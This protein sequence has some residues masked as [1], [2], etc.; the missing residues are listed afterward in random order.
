MRGFWSLVI[1]V[2]LL[3]CSDTNI[4]A[5]SSP[6]NHSTSSTPYR[7]PS[8]VRDTTWNEVTNWGF[9]NTLNAQGWVPFDMSKPWS[10]LYVTDTTE[11]VRKGWRA[12][13]FEV[14]YG[15]CYQNDCTRS[16]VYERNEWAENNLGRECD[17]KECWYGYSFYAPPPSGTEVPWVFFGQFNQHPSGRSPWMFLKRSNQDFCAIRDWMQYNNWNC[18]G[19][20]WKLLDKDDF[21]GSWHDIVI[22]ARWHVSEGFTKIWVDDVLVV[23]YQGPTKNYGEVV[24][25]KY[26]IYRHRPHV[27]ITSVMYYDELRRGNSRAEVDIRILGN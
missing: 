20:N 21:Y 16:P 3:G 1:V 17:D 23:D 25:F 10:H 24:Y 15:D 12:Q 22:H 11:A 13:R 7:H 8:W 2:F 19:Q 14:Q 26:G 9:I 6:D 4:I 18:T 27:P 5:P